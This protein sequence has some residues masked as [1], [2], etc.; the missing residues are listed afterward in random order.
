M[1]KG[2]R[3]GGFTLIELLVVIAIIAILAA[4]LLP[5]LGRAREMARR[6]SCK[7]N[8]RQLGLAH[9]MYVHDWDGFFVPFVGDP[10]EVV[11]WPHIFHNLG[12]I[13]VV[14]MVWACPSFRSPA[15]VGSWIHYG[16]NH[17]NIGH[18]FWVDR[19]ATPARLVRIA[20]PS[21]TILLID[22]HRRDIPHIPLGSFIVQCIPGSHAPHV[23]HSD[24][25]NI[26]WVDG[27]VSWMAI[28]DPLNPW[29][30]LGMAHIPPN[31]WDRR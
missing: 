20:N 27:H 12:Y 8:L 13:D 25:L 10:P 29:A 30:E 17:L 26:L 1:K 5:A 6:T 18:S 19:T 24:G 22:T 3:L 7:S 9:M 31:Y 16:Y 14:S 11:R 15:H 28:A 23:R 2:K 21:E 4:M